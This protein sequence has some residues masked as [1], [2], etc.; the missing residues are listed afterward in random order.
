MPDQNLNESVV[1]EMKSETDAD[2]TAHQ[3]ETILA[4][5]AKSYAKGA[6]EDAI[7]K[8]DAAD[9]SAVDSLIQRERAAR[10]TGQWAE[11]AN[12]YHPKSYVEVSW[13][14][15][16][17]TDFVKQ[18]SLIAGGKVYTFH[19]MSP[20][21]VML[22][23]DRALAE[24]GCTVHGLTELEGVEIDIVSQSRLLWRAQK[25][26]AGWLIAGMRAY[27]LSDAIIAADPTKVP[28]IDHAI[29]DGLRRSYRSIAYVMARSGFPVRD[30]LAGID[31]PDTVASLRAK[32]MEWLAG[33]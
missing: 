12:C 33:S 16:A 13:F 4:V 10:D 28:D 1:G 27:Y 9:Q 3:G 23:G 20:A 5:H 7:R 31:R 17:G 15:G 25:E 26:K 8:L 18:S 19:I 21:V 2:A 14:Q 11:M 6:V 30:D 29:F 24:T 32:E 22:N